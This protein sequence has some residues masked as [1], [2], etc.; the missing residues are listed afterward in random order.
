[1]DADALLVLFELTDRKDERFLL[2]AARRATSLDDAIS[3]RARSSS[4]AVS[5]GGGSPSSGRR[6]SGLSWR[7]GVR[8]I[9]R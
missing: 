2:A 5:K 3:R 8:T 6:F 1:M 7:H 9:E 4:G